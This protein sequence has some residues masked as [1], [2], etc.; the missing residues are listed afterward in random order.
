M[1][2]WSSGKEYRM[3]TE[4]F[5]IEVYYVEEDGAGG[6]EWSAT[7][8]DN[9]NLEAFDCQFDTAGTAMVGADEWVKRR[10][11]EGIAP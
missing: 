4:D 9:G 7:R 3:I 2:E 6:W 1:M 8:R 5:V 10:Q 11:C